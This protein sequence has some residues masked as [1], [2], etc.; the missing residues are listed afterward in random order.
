MVAEG[1][2]GRLIQDLLQESPF[3]EE[4]SE[5]SYSSQPIEPPID[6]TSPAVDAAWYLG[7]DIGTTGISAVLLNQATRHLYPVYWRE[8]PIESANEFVYSSSAPESS[9]EK[10]FRLPM[11]VALSSSPS[12]SS[13]EAYRVTLA[14]PATHQ[15]TRGEPST[16]SL[17]ALQDFKPHLKLAIPYHSAHFDRAEP[18][19]Q[20]S[21]QHSVPLV[22]LQQALSTLLSTLVQSAAPLAFSCNALGFAEADFS[23]VLRQLQGMVV[24]CPAEASDTYRFN[25]R[26]AILQTKLIAQPAQIVFLEDAIATMLSALASAD[27]PPIVLPQ[28]LDSTLQ[29]VQWQGNTLIF[30]AGATV[31]ELGFVTLPDRPTDLTHADFQTRSLHYAGSAIDQ[32]IISQLLYPAL[33]ETA[34]PLETETEASAQWLSSLNP[35]LAEPQVN[36]S[37]ESIDLKELGLEDFTFPMPGEPEIEKRH[38]LQQRLASTASGQ[39]LLEAAETLKLALQQQS[40]F[41]IK[42]PHYRA[43][44]LRQDLTTKV[45]LPYVQRLN[46]E[47]NTLLSQV[48]IAPAQVDQVIC[49]GG[50]ASLA[51][52]ARWLRQKLP[53]A[54]IVQ[55]AYARSLRS[56]HCIPS[57]SRIAYG[58]AALP[59]YPQLLDRS[60]QQYSDYFLLLELLRVF[61]SQPISLTEILHQLEK[62]GIQTAICRSRIQALL[63]GNLPT[64]LTPDPAEQALL[65]PESRSNPDYQAIHLAPLFQREGDTYQINRYQWNHLRHYLERLLANKHQSLTQPY[66][67]LLQPYS[68][69]QAQFRRE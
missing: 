24:G 8:Q 3:Y 63:E 19:L 65:T 67:I 2:L 11:Q 37:L 45:L 4:G 35:Q 13:P 40:R 25:L 18:I 39:Q 59:L 57:C 44:V 31:T 49:T 27:E 51:A 16:H 21:D 12:A 6:Q 46:R 30:Q 55:D 14:H 41:P 58:L 38:Q 66:A 5:N 56:R 53:N 61:P 48:D 42:L 43:I 17:T 52:V 47:L 68:S 62:R 64:G 15:A 9:L 32:D 1:T 29:A 26:E 22:L 69:T 36:F 7:I 10:W 34:Q 20:W 60:R 28:P 50:T 33:L 54:M 23:R